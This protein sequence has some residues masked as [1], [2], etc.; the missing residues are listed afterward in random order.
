MF[1]FIEKILF[2][3]LTFNLFLKNEKIQDVNIDSGKKPKKALYT[4]IRGQLE[5]GNPHEYFDHQK[6]LIT[7]ENLGMNLPGKIYSKNI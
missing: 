2:Y 6:R 4:P 7:L 5:E 1:L 3:F